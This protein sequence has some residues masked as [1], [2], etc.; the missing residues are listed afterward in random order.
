VTI[1]AEHSKNEPCLQA[2]DYFL[3]ALQ[4]YYE[5]NESRYIELMWPK[6]G[7]IHDLDV[8]HGTKRGAFYTQ[9]KP[10]IPPG[11]AASA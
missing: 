1:S 11:D 4:R 2:C 7:E 9:K 10:L 5:R 6:V 3:W 8:E